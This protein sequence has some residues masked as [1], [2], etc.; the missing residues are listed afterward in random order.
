MRYLSI[1]LLVSLIGCNREN[2]LPDINSTIINVQ[3]QPTWQTKP[4]NAE[5]SI[6]FPKSYKG[7]IGPTI[8]GPQFSLQN[9]DASVYLLDPLPFSGGGTPLPTPPPSS[10]VYGNLTLDKTVLFR[11]NNQTQGIL[12]YA[13][14]PQTRARFYLLRNGQLVYNLVV[15][16]NFDLHR[17]VLGI[18]Q[19][20][21]PR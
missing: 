8:E 17:E 20:I 18:L 21:Q 11:R 5:Y 4:L 16:Y 9:E 15:R 10:M 2:V 7:G 13:R 6:Q 3:S 19:T 12:Y 1:F 14:Q